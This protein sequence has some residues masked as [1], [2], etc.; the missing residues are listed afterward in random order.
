MRRTR[1]PMR[2]DNSA[3]AAAWFRRG[4]GR[5]AAA[6]K[7]RICAEIL[8]DI[9][10]LYGAQLSGG[11]QVLFAASPV[12]R[13]L[14][15]GQNGGDLCA[16]WRE[17]PFETDALDLLILDHAL[18]ASAEP[19]AVLREAAR[20]LRPQGRLLVIGFNPWS[21]LALSG[22]VPWRRR[23][24]SVARIK[25]WLTL[26]DMAPR[27]GVYAMFLP[28]WGR[29]RWLRWMDPAGRRWWP[30]AGGVFFLDAVKRRP[31]IRMMPAP[32]QPLKKQKIAALAAAEKRIQ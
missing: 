13:C 26:L 4:V 17:L 23:W 1:P 15:I 3:T 9:F 31:D 22:D 20:V 27:G 32:F 2:N 18:E 25:D 7:R 12:R 10:G 28:P 6:E 29:R 21:L 30:L 8:R 11:G 24:L 5:R 16:D 14:F 19:H